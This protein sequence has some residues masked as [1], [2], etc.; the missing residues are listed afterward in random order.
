MNWE[1]QVLESWVWE[2]KQEIELLGKATP[3]CLVSLARSWGMCRLFGLPTPTISLSLAEAR[4]ALEH[5]ARRVR[6]YIADVACLSDDWYEAATPETDGL[7][8]DAMQ[9]HLN[10][11]ASGVAFNEILETNYGTVP[12]FE[13][14]LQEYWDRVD[15]F[16]NALWSHRRYMPRWLNG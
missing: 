7:C 16:G 8:F 15:G 10:A 11:I 14:A 3:H 12:H 5:S 13:E 6:E 2:R 9:N 4:I 1:L